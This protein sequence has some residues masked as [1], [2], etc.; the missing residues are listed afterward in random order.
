M[1]SLL[2]PKA[3]SIRRSQALQVELNLSILTP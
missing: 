3:E 1:L 2:N